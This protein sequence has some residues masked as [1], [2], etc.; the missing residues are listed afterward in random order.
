M[1]PEALSKLMMV[2]L[3][4]VPVLV[5]VLSLFVKRWRGR[6]IRYSVIAMAALLVLTYL[7]VTMSG[8]P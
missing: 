4:A 3:F 8:Q 2:A 1:Y 6:L 5:A 7:T